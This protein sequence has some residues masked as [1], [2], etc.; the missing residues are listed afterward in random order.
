VILGDAKAA[1]HLGADRDRICAPVSKTPPPGE[2]IR[3]PI[4]RSTVEFEQALSL[5]VA[6]P[7]A[8]GLGVELK[9]FL[10]I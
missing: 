2:I 9:T 6:S 8:G 3:R 10:V 4:A 1:S 7:A 5:G